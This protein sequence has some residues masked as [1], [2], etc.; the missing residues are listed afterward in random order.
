MQ[1]PIPGRAVGLPGVRAR[2]ARHPADADRHTVH[3]GASEPRDRA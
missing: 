3:R 2:P 1:P